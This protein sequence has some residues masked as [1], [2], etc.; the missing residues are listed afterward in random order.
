[1]NKSEAKELLDA[2]H[3]YIHDEYGEGLLSSMKEDFLKWE[4][5]ENKEPKVDNKE[6]LK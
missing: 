1:M 6:L 5:A 4:F 3:Q 2:F